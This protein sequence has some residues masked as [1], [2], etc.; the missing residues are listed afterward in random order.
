MAAVEEHHRLED[1]RVTRTK[2][3]NKDY[4]SDLLCQIDHQKTNKDALKMEE[5]REYN[6]GLKTEAEYQQRLKNV[7]SS[8]TYASKTHPMRKTQLKITGQKLG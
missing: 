7:L 3:I 5:L 8:A 2:K 4:E 1:E 6:E